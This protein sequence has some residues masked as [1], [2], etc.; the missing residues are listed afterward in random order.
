MPQAGPVASGM[1]SP[2]VMGH[3]RRSGARAWWRCAS[4]WVTVN[5]PQGAR[6]TRGNAGRDD[7]SQARHEHQPPDRGPGLAQQAARHPMGR[8]APARHH[9]PLDFQVGMGPRRRSGDEI[10]L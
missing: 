1:S 9:E 7:R 5:T 8:A 3:Y 2:Q 10:Q 4:T 6:S